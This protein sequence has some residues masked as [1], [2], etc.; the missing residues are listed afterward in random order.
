[1]T[2]YLGAGYGEHG[3][4]DQQTSCDST[5]SSNTSTSYYRA[6]PLFITGNK[7]RDAAIGEPRIRAGEII[8]S[9]FW[10]LRNGILESA[11]VSYTWRSGIFERSSFIPM[12]D[13]NLGYHAL[14]NNF[15]YHAFREADQRGI[16]V[17]PLV[18]FRYWL[19]GHV[20][21]SRRA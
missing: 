5:G 19:R 15:G 14:G 10:K 17:H 21:R 6:E 2:N 13:Q 16:N 3:R 18:A 7:A 1:M 9:R 11:F 4:A 12:K 8:G 20:G